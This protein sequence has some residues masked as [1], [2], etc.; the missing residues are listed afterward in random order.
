MRIRVLK[1]VA[2]GHDQIGCLISF[3]VRPHVLEK[4][5][6]LF[7]HVVLVQIRIVHDRISF[8]LLVKAKMRRRRIPIR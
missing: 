2:H 3:G 1:V 4:P 6:N 8:A 5:F 7:I